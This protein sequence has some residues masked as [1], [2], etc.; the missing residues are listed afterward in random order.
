VPTGADRVAARPRQAVNPMAT[1]EGPARRPRPRPRAPQPSR[2]GMAS[3]LPPLRRLPAGARPARVRAGERG[4]RSRARRGAADAAAVATTVKA[5]RRSVEISRP[6]KQPAVSVIVPFAGPSDEPARL[7]SELA[8]L[9]L[10]PGDALI[11]ADNRGTAANSDLEGSG[12]ST[13]AISIRTGRR[14]RGERPRRRGRRPLL[15]P[16]G[17]R[18]RGRGASPAQLT[19]RFARDAEQSTRALVRR[20]LQA[21]GPSLLDSAGGLAFELGR[22]LPNGRASRRRT[23]GMSS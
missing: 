18:L 7:G 15:P 22:L 6:G 2:V 4:A 16:P 19:R 20:D 23:S 3:R 11:V 14:V 12:S 8:R 1:R 5:G 13:P 9:R 10:R 21:A 17:R